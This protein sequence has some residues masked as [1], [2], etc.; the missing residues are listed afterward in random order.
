MGAVGAYRRGKAEAEEMNR[1]RT[2]IM[3]NDTVKHQPSGEI[4]VVCGVN[5]ESGSLIPM[6]Y[7]FPSIANVADCELI[8]RHYETKPQSEKQ[9]KA[10]QAH[11]LT[12]YIDARSAC[13]HGII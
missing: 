2:R 7:P 13:F 3:P 12:G 1:M 4:W 8:E 6:G 5:H 11:G 10:L 9:I